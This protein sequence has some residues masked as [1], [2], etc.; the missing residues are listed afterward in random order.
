MARACTLSDGGGAAKFLSDATSPDVVFNQL[1]GSYFSDWNHQNDFLRAA[2]AG[3]GYGLTSTSSL[4]AAPN[5]WHMGMGETVGDNLVFTQKGQP[6]VG[7]GSYNA[8]Q[9]VSRE[10]ALMGDPTLRMA[11]VKPATDVHAA[12]CIS[13]EGQDVGAIVSWTPSP[14]QTVI[15]YRLYR[16]TSMDG[17][18]VRVGGDLSASSTYFIDPTGTNR[19][20]TGSVKYTYMVRAVKLET[21]NTG[22][23]FNLSQGA[24]SQVDSGLTV[25]VG[26]TSRASVDSVAFTFTQPVVVGAGAIELRRRGPDG[27]SLVQDIAVSTDDGGLSYVVTVVNGLGHPVPFG[28]G[29]F[30]ISVYLGSVS[31]LNSTV[32]LNES[33]RMYAF[34]RYAGDADGDGDVS[35]TDF[36]IL[37][38][39]FGTDHN[40][41]ADSNNDGVI[42]I[43]D[44]NELATRF[45]TSVWSLI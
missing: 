44:F 23:Y 8:L 31:V 4:G 14:D 25:G 27:E 1:F 2:I 37:A 10:T 18:F 45:G 26:R 21:S 30:D 9:Y 35:I 42:D 39:S 33:S 17:P 19:D 13:E 12:I 29:V 11:V 16:A 7:T 41:D 32:V 43:A 22:S 15:G 20:N 3:N 28:D 38:P 6:N 24:F 36:N 40:L 5:F 34:F